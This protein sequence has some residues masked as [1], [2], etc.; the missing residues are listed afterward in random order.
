MLAGAKVANTS[1]G[2]R[3]TALYMKTHALAESAFVNFRAGDWPKYRTAV[4]FET[5]T[6]GNEALKRV[7][8][9]MRETGVA[10]DVVPM[11]WSFNLLESGIW[12]ARTTTG[13]GPPASAR[14]YSPSGVN[15]STTFV[16][17]RRNALT[18][19]SRRNGATVLIS[20]RAIGPVEFREFD[21][22]SSGRMQSRVLALALYGA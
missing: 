5:T 20:C 16:E 22:S 7:E 12:R 1:T 10:L 6:A 21:V 19:R 14:M 9:F 13:F 2:L 3:K 18:V 15:R 17:S 11:L 4:L 8:R